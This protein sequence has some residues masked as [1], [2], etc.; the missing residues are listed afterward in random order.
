MK[1]VRGAER[2]RKGE[3][4]KVLVLEESVSLGEKQLSGWEGEAAEE[5]GQHLPLLE[6]CKSTANHRQA[7]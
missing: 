6:G 3:I 5:Q 1:V 2:M 7:T 4:P